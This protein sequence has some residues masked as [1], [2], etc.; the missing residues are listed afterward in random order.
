VTPAAIW[1]AVVLVLAAVTLFWML[2]AYNRLVSLRNAVGAAWRTVD[3]LL[4]ARAAAV[5]SLL[6]ALREP[7]AGEAAALDA[8]AAAQARVADAARTMGDHAVRADA[9][10]ALGQAE[11][12]F[13]P[14]GTR[15][16]A[17]VE[18]E[19]VLRDLEAVQAPLAALHE[20]APRLAF[21]RQAFNDA[22]QAHNGA[23]AQWPTR[24]LARLY[25]FVPGGTL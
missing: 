11:A 12:A 10:V 23:I 2:G 1:Q 14:A 16:R 24:L 25:G 6:A 22:M 3:E 15:V 19:A 20:L 7:L 8:L 18:A 4:A 9:A 17:L 13:G 5:G 21:A